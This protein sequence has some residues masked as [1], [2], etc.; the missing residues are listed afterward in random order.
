MVTK[1]LPVG[2]PRVNWFDGM[3]VDRDDMVD[4]QT[5]NRD[6]DAAN[7]HNFFSS[8]VIVKTTIPTVILD[9]DDLSAAQ[10][11]L[12]DADVFDGQSIYDNND[13]VSDVI[14][15][16]LL[17]VTLSD[18][19]LDGKA[20]SKV[21]IIGDTFGDV[22]VHD[23][24]V[25][26]ENGTQITRG[27]YKKIRSI[28]FSDFAGNLRGSTPNAVDSDGYLSGQ[29]LI[30]EA[31]S[32]EA[33]PDTI[34]AQQ[35]SQPNKFFDDFT[36]ANWTTTITTMLDTA[37]KADDDAKSLADLDIGLVSAQQRTLAAGDVTTKIGQKFQADGNNIQKISVLLS[38]AYDAVDGYNWSGSVILSV[39]ELQT[40]VSCPVSP[41]PDTAEDF[42]PDPRILGQLSLDKDDLEKQGIVLD[43]YTQIVDFVFTNTNISDPI[44]SPIT[45]GNYYA[46]T[47]HR[48]GDTSTGN[49]L[50]EE[51]PHR[52]LTGYMIVYDG[53]QWINIKDSDMWYIVYGDYIKVSDGIAYEDGV[54]IEVPKI[55][56]DSTNTEVPYVSGPH[57]FSLVTRDAYNYIIM[58]S[59][60]EFSGPTQDQRTGNLISSRVK[61]I[62]SFSLISL[63]SLNTLLESNPT[64]LLLG[65]TRD[66]NPRA[67][68]EIVTG[69]T[70][71]VGLVRRNE[72]NVLYPDADMLQHN[73]VGSLLIPN[74]TSCCETYRIIKTEVFNDAYGDID[75]DGTITN[76]DIVTLQAVRQSY[77]NYTEAILGPGFGTNIIDLSTSMAQQFVVDGYVDIEVL[78]RSDV[79]ANGIINNLDEGLIED[80]VNKIIFSF[81]AGSTFARMMLTVENIT[82]PLTTTVVIPDACP[83]FTTVPFV[84]VDW[85]I[86]YFP[87]W[88]PDLVTVHDA[89]RKLATTISDTVSGC[90][91]GQN[92][93]FIPGDLLLGGEILNPDGTGFRIDF[94]MT[95]LSLH[96]PITDAYGSPIFIDG[97]TGILLFETFVAEEAGGKTTSGFNAM[98]YSDNSYVQQT[99]FDDGKVKI[100]PSIQSTASN[101]TVP[102][103]GDITDIVGLNY[104]PDSSLMTLYLEDGYEDIAEPAVRTKILVEVYLKKAGFR[105]STQN[106]TDS[107]IRALLGI[108]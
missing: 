35:T 19:A 98:K 38:S 76:A 66:R 85:R 40:E 88:L 28:I 48:S 20:Q 43:G 31:D 8:G 42:D 77:Y 7:V 63:S 41:V 100:A 25:F 73:W 96:I 103:G 55:Q 45:P 21:S 24:L 67:N 107:E 47:V 61:P 39:Y 36:P 22:L 1:R 71:V 37:I 90:D 60:S 15:G 9:T 12:F 3:Q 57:E 2:I 64:P 33:S 70:E 46:F 29:C 80:F 34:L 30:V 4:E 86:E 13:N 26:N 72:F 92:N 65:C 17:S 93:F 10:Q 6:I 102:F 32:V 87:T 78:L 23:D 101:F 108:V 84:D 54:G 94:E 82:D 56:K 75:G 52:A 16:V 53:S 59:Q 69:T 81:P 58:E 104:D 49:L 105:N 97:Y 14:K 95:H 79:D 91:G 62:P 11:A 27:R 74:S 5:R 106:I 44:R 50:V 68:T 51:A 18:T 99:D 83:S 89:R